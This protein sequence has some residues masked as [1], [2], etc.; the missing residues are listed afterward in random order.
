[1]LSSMSMSSTDGLGA[2]IGVNRNARVAHIRKFVCVPPDR[3]HTLRLIAIED[4][5][6][7]LGEWPRAQCED[8]G[9]TAEDVDARLRDHAN[10]VNAETA[11]NLTWCAENH[12][13]VCS[14]R[15]KCKPDSP[16]DSAMD[17]ASAA[18]AEAWG[19]NGSVKGEALQLGRAL[20]GHIRL[21][22]TDA[23]TRR[24]EDRARDKMQIELIQTL[25]TMVREGWT[26]AH[27]AN[28][29]A[30]R[31]RMQQRRELD[32]AALQLR[33]ALPEGDPENEARGELINQVGAALTQAFP[34]IL[35]HVVK[36]L[37]QVPDNANATPLPPASAAE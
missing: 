35:Q 21:Y 17:P 34:F 20:E 14:K 3:G 1:M 12:L 31:L 27:Q 18:Q 5:A 33:E 22:M 19:V 16:I 9:V 4:P 30:D 7:V 2:P 26:A 6:T 25:G 37:A 36:A 13:V 11:A 15:L 28:A 32:A 24:A 29:E 23:Q 8:N 10:T